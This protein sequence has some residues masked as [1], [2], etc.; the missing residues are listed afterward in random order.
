[1]NPPEVEMPTVPEYPIKG[2]ENLS[3]LEGVN[4]LGQLPLI[5]KEELPAPPGARNRLS[6]LLFTLHQMSCNELHVRPCVVGS[7]DEH[8]VQVLNSSVEGAPAEGLSVV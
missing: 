7:L 8:L 1:M 4:V 6:G 3:H 2:V 5:L